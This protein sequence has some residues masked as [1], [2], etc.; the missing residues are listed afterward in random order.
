MA[1]IESLS[2]I[3]DCAFN[4]CCQKQTV[5]M[6]LLSSQPLITLAKIPPCA[7]NETSANFD[8]FLPVENDKS[9]VNHE[10]SIGTNNNTSYY[11]PLTFVFS[12]NSNK[13]LIQKCIPSGVL[14]PSQLGLLGSIRG[15]ENVGIF[16]TKNQELVFHMFH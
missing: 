1:L 8:P 10:Q 12:G 14:A 7:V 15:T 9:K 13:P 2:I 6:S 16:S 11:R 5:P 3:T 4:E